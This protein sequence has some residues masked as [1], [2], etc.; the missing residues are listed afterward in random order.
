MELQ[1]VYG[2]VGA[3]PDA[4]TEDDDWRAILA[5]VRSVLT[6]GNYRRWF[7]GTCVVERC[8]GI[9]RVGVSDAFQ[10]DWLE[11]RLHGRVMDAVASLRAVGSLRHTTDHIEYVMRA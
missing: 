2:T 5:E 11:H 10:R 7:A 8:Q 3:P 4:E 6:D 9:L 1:S